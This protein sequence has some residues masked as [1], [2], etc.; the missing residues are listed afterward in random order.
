MNIR[1]RLPAT[2][3]ILLSA[4]MLSVTTPLDAQ[5]TPAL[6]NH[7]KGTFDVKTIPQPGDAA[8]DGGFGRLLL[9]KTFHGAL[10]ATSKGTMLGFQA[11]DKSGA[12]YVALELVT[13]TLDG[14]EGSFVLQHS[15]TMRGAEQ[16]LSITVVPGSGTGQLAGLAGD[17]AIQIAG[18]QHSYDFAYTLNPAKPR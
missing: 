15:G 10:N 17:F 4:L 14:R 2:F 7:A 12:G 8:V 11:V 18:K 6:P 3:R 16:S 1:L 13:G 5:R 9:D